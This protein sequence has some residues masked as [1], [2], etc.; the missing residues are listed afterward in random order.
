[1]EATLPLQGFNND[2]L[3]FLIVAVCICFVAFFSSSE[4]ALMSANRI[5][6]KNLIE[7]GDKNAILV[8]KIVSKHERLF[9]T[10]LATE[11]MFIIFASTFAGSV[12]EKYFQGGNG[13][14]I[15]SFVMTIFIV[16]FGEITPKTFAA[17]HALNMALFAAKPINF[18]IHL[19]S[20]F[21]SVLSF[22]SKCIIKLLG[23][24]PDMNPYFLTEEEIRM[25]ISD[26][27]KGGVLDKKETEMIE[28]V[29]EF[30][31]ATAQEVMVPRVRMTC[32][33]ADSSVADLL[34]IITETGHSR[35]PVQKGSPD[36]IIGVA[37]AK[38]VLKYY[39]KDLTALKTSEIMRQCHYA[40]ET[41]S[42]RSLLANL[43]ENKFTIAIIIDEFGGTAGLVTI[44]MLI[45]EIVGDIDDEFDN[46]KPEIEQLENGE[47]LAD[48]AMGADDAGEKLGIKFPEGD[49]QTIGG[50]LIETIGRI[51]SVGDSV[52][53]EGHE[54]IVEKTDS[55]HISQIRVRR[56]SSE[57]P[58]A[59]EGKGEN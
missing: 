50:Y 3:S 42:I 56:K 45:E 51:P 32:V 1:M 38:D 58:K 57:P 39:D 47:W 25:V 13:V 35:V 36:N 18:F 49:F 24:K 34:K 4:A 10:I 15:S 30:S 12:A 8:E 46:L 59:S 14:I 17:Q 33:E 2:F 6:L 41:Q 21:V 29:F 22:I 28:G 52:T 27:A 26:G 19:L 7:K 43:R 9:A 55:T 48:A 31:K 44:E 16:I 54:L 37:Y 23:V 11:N 53:I 40:P 5:K 20:P